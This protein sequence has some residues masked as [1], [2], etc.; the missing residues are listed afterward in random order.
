MNRWV[1]ISIVLLMGLSGCMVSKSKYE[2][3]VADME[4]AKAEL[5]KSRMHQ[6]ALEEQI[7]NLKG[8]NEKVST[9]LETMTT[10][11][12]RIKEGRKNEHTLLETRERELDQ[13]KEQLTSKLR[14]VVDQY[15]KVKAQNKALKETVL[16]Y[17]KELK[18]TRESSIGMAAGAM[19]PSENPDM[20]KSGISPPG[21]SP[22]VS[23]KSPSAKI[24]SSPTLP[25]M[26]GDLVNINKAPVSDL[27]LTLGLTR[28]VA[29][30][31]VSNRPYRL[32]GEL[33]AKNIIPKA[34]FDGIKDRI[35]ASP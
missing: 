23:S 15:Q 17:Q 22:I 20:A 4:S 1:V 25:K 24:V 11:V 31:V 29:E 2:A 6:E 19:K 14:V 33:V 3:S 30:E 12:Q 5:E 28:E 35:T 7:R 9:D 18:D 27:V 10:E 8:L 16:R 21:A 26:G 32:R 13:E 34:T